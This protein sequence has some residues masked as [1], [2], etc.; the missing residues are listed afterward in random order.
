MWS[1]IFVIPNINIREAVGN[2]HIS[3]VLYDDPIVTEC[4]TVGPLCKALIENFQDEFGRLVYPS[5]LIM[6][7]D[8]P[9]SVKH[10]E[11]IVGFRNALALSTIIR[12]YEHRLTSAFVAYPLY[13][14]Y[15]DFY[16]MT[17]GR[18]DGGYIKQSP[19]MLGWEDECTSFKGQMSPGLGAMDM[20]P[21]AND[22]ILELILKAWERRYVKPHAWATRSLF[23]SLEMAYQATSMPFRNYS[24]IYDYGSSASLW[25]SAFEV[26]SHPRKGRANPESVLNM[27]GGYQW[28]RSMLGR[29]AYRINYRKVRHSVNLVQKLYKELYDTRNHFLHGDTVQ[30]SSLYPFGNRRTQPLTRFAPLIY[31]IALMS[32]L[33]M[34]KQT[35]GRMQKLG[36]H[37]S[38]SI[39]ELQLSEAIMKCKGP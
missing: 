22:P 10:I 34:Y 32:V 17:V 25:G 24:S 6:S 23:R 21:R 1:L 36:R 3:I 13:S 29:K 14:D 18:D 31:K 30:Q 39:E 33:E 2:E 26:L 9:A 35:K 15:F 38:E 11:A 7:K 4:T 8:A 19:S 12:G 20:H 27:L 37:M 28:H 16:P 5:A